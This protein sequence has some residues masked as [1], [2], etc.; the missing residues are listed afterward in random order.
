MREFTDQLEKRLRSLAEDSSIESARFRSMLSV[1][2]VSV[3]PASA[4]AAP[5]TSTQ[6]GEGTAVA[7]GPLPERVRID[8]GARTAHD[9]PVGR[10][11][12]SRPESFPKPAATRTWRSRP[13]W[14]VLA[15]MSGAVAAVASVAALT[16]TSAA[17]LPILETETSD[18]SAAASAPALRAAGVDLRLGHAFPTANGPGYV[19]ASPGEER[20]CLTAPAP[21]PG[22]TYSGT[23]AP[24]STVERRGLRLEMTGDLARDP[25]ASNLVVV[26]LPAGATSARLTDRRGTSTPALRAGVFTAA[27]RA[28]AVLTFLIRGKPRQERFQGP[29]DGTRFSCRGEVVPTPATSSKQGSASADQLTACSG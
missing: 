8:R 4:G 1:V 15:G 14:T 10:F 25:D 27:L 17:G 19:L 29:F 6:H 23:C 7:D 16:A 22:S 26:L 13:R 28:P 20:L 5:D 9:L 12:A 18:A 2:P 24:R 11:R 3:P 21:G